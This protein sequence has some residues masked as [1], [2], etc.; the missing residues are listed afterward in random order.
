[1][2]IRTMN[3]NTIV[4]SVEK[5]NELLAES[6][7]ELILME[8]TDGQLTIAPIRP[9]NRILLKDVNEN[10]EK[11]S[12]EGDKKYDILISNELQI[13]SVQKSVSDN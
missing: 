6:K 9:A 8:T 13:M 1:M 4:L 7:L 2:L 11:K 5:K 10:G 12:I 3:K